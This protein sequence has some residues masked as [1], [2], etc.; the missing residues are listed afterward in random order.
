MKIFDTTLI[1]APEKNVFDLSH[2][3]KTSAKFDYIVP[4]LCQEVLPGSTWNCRAEVFLRTMPLI[5]PILHNVDMKVHYFF[6]PNRIIWPGQTKM[7]DSQSGKVALDSW[8]TFITGGETGTFF[9]V[10]PFLEVDKVAAFSKGYLA[11]RSLW[12]YLGLPTISAT[13]TK[14]ITS[15]T[16]VSS[17][18]FRA[19]QKVYNEY[20]RNQNIQDEVTVPE[21]SGDDITAVADLLTLRKKCWEKDYFTSC[22]P[23]VQRGEAVHLPI[24][25]FG[26]DIPVNIKYDNSVFPAPDI[27]R[28]VGGSDIIDD[29]RLEVAKKGSILTDYAALQVTGSVN[30]GVNIDNSY[31]LK[32]EISKNVQFNVDATINDLRLAYRLQLWLENNARCGSRYI[33]QL[34]SHFGVTSSDARLQ[35]PELLGGGSIPLIVTDVENNNATND[36]GPQGVLAGKGTMFGKTG[37]FKKYFEE[38]G[39][40]IGVFSIIPRTSYQQGIPRQFS[41]KTR[42]DYAF[43]EFANLGEQAVLNKEIYFDFYSEN[44]KDNED[45]FGY[46]Q[47]FCEYRY[48]P[49]SVHGELR[50]T[51]QFW[52]LGR[53]F[54]KRPALNSAFVTS[55]TRANVFAVDDVQNGETDPFVVEIHNDVRS[56]LP[57]PKFAIPSL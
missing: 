23:F 2:D 21:G 35:R 37:G 19:Y 7:I 17:L 28:T 39:W 5:A 6:V 34:R 52:H 31:H 9:P 55:N 43:P 30:E 29:S 45:T 12:D 10:A 44:D 38:H 4:F 25:Q 36:N 22:L 13:D 27:V 49:S 26:Q 56:L 8:Q 54:D 15:K 53:I 41:R 32:G 20:F 14:A 40:I 1:K 42:Y 33:E 11:P 16:K 50:D 18:P 51:L 57:L 46:Q 47:R 24:S 48:I 3:V